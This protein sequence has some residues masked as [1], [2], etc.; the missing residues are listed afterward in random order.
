[1]A[2][3][4]RAL[5]AAATPGPWFYDSY[6][7]VFCSAKGRLYDDIE[8]PECV[9]PAWK[10]SCDEPRGSCHGCPFFEHDYRE[11]PVVAFVQPHHGDTAIGQRSADAEFVAAVS[12]DVVVGLLDELDTLRRARRITAESLRE[13]AD[14]LD[15]SLRSPHMAAE[16]MRETA[17]E[18]DPPPGGLVPPWERGDHGGTTTVVSGDMAV[19]LPAPPDVVARLDELARLR[20]IVDDVAAEGTPTNDDGRCAWC[21]Y[22]L[23]SLPS[24][25]PS[26]AWLKVA[27][28]GR[29]EQ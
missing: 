3:D 4:L 21:G 11:S 22:Y 23:D 19:E 15:Q 14:E 5:A 26:C 20:A 27:A 10:T 1:V 8:F 17:D 25:A 18:L 24:H 2:D 6:S 7:R 12:P 28:F 9:V 13:Q 29:E 16:C